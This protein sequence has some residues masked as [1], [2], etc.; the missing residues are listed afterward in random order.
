MGTDACEECEELRGLHRGDQTVSRKQSWSSRLVAET[1]RDLARGATYAD[2]SIRMRK[3]TGRTRTRTQ[4][5]PGSARP[6]YTGSRLARNAWH[7]A[8]DWCETF[9]PV[10]WGHVEAEL[11]AGN[12]RDSEE[13]ERLWLAGTP[14]P[15]P[16]MVLIDDIPINARFVDEDG[17]N[18]SRRDYFVLVVAEVAWGQTVRDTIDR[19]L[20]LR[21]V[22]AYPSN[23]HHAYKLLFDELGYT[24]DFILADAGKGLM[25]AVADFYKGGITFVP[26]LFHVRAAVE[27]GLFET[28]GAWVRASTRAPKELR[29]DVGSH[30]AGLRK[31]NL[32]TMTVP[33][34][35]GW[36]NDL[37][38]LL[39]SIG[40]PVEPTRRRRK[41]YEQAIADILP[42][43]AA[44][45]QLPVST[46]GVEVAIRKRIEP[47]LTNRAH[48]FANLER[49]NRL[50]DLVVCDDYGL[51]DDIG[52]VVSLLRTDSADNHGWSTPLRAVA[53]R[54]PPKTPARGK[55]YSSLRDQQLLRDI[56]RAKGLA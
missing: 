36:W 34:W 28:Q 48:A 24:P 10:L 45:P 21:L 2:A 23:D 4:P 17:A 13:R 22:R 35:S 52:L 3:V 32:T 26:S 12:G 9:S 46:G 33:E 37:E 41:N 27:K 8:A 38:A 50:F 55:P 43:L 39:S 1:L 19:Q 31:K 56:T 15:T 11:V 7:I 6:T 40:A 42:T 51:F 29:G 54:Q 18:S 20:R 44:L 5:V 53:D 25:K 14:N 16:M 30:L 47:M 49:T